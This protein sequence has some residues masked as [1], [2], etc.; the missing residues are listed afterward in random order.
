MWCWHSGGTGLAPVEKYKGFW[1]AMVGGAPTF[2][3]EDNPN[4]GGTRLVDVNGDSRADWVYVFPDGHTNI[5]TNAHG[6]KADGKGLKPVWD[7]AAKSHP[8]FPEEKGALLDNIKFGRIYGT[9][10]ADY[11]KVVETKDGDN[12]Q[13]DFQIFKN[14]GRGGT[15]VKG[16]GVHYCGKFSASIGKIALILLVRYVSK[17]GD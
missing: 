11:I 4:I 14:E 2:D 3:P 1:E 8:G 5:F 9:G 6:T 10:K 13:Y 17:P 15:Q 16:D 12:Y 7:K